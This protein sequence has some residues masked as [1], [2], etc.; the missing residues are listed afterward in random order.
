MTPRM[1]S[2]A[3]ARSFAALL[4]SLTSLALA[5]AVLVIATGFVTAHDCPNRL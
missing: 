5:N 4:A 2:L 3:Y 1:L